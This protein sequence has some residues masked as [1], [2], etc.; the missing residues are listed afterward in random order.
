[1][2]IQGKVWGTTSQLFNKN[3]VEIHRITGIKG[4]YCSKHYHAS[5]FNQFFV[6]KGSLIVRI[7]KGEQVDETVLKE[8]MS[9]TI[10][11]NEVHQFEVLEEG[12]VA[13]EIYWT[14]LEGEDIVR[15]SEGGG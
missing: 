1:M 10:P 12:T 4:G 3:N 8:G 9:C 15:L 11:P 5:K 6:E 13:Y 7:W 14:E 2:N